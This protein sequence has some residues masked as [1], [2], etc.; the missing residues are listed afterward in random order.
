MKVQI[1][2]V[3]LGRNDSVEFSVG[4]IRKTGHI[5]GHTRFRKKTITHIKVEGEPDFRIEDLP[6][7]Q[8]AIKPDDRF[9]HISPMSS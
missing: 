2:S 8:C 6:I 7:N 5:S 1:Y 3:R 4:D 9:N